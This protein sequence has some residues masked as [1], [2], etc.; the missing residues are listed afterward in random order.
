MLIRRANRRSAA[1]RNFIGRNPRGRE[2]VL[3]L[4]AQ[5]RHEGGVLS[6]MYK[7]DWDDNECP[8]GYL[9]TVR[10]YGTWLHGDERG[11]VDRHGKNIF[12]TPRIVENENLRTLM[13]EEMSAESF[14]LNPEQIFVVDA[15]I[16][17]VCIRR[18]YL[19]RALNV[20]TN[21]FHAVVSA[22]RKP[23]LIA[24]AFKSNATRA[25][26]EKN[27]VS[28]ES[29]IW[30]RGRSRRYLWKPHQLA[31]AVDYALNQ[32]GSDLL[33]SFD[34]WMKKYGTEDK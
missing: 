5:R 4:D 16:R 15:E 17:A 22:P 33:L 13:S 9:I 11:S 19:L 30:S 1:I 7:D 20:R 31:G 25:L 27:L 24:N 12:G 14:I 21:H 34:E 29:A 8:L 26:R 10:T 32:Q 28:P 23:E 3:L 6:A 2:G 18:E